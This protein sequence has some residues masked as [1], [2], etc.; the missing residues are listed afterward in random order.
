MG[1]WV[2]LEDATKDNGCMWGVPGSH[3]E[4]TTKFFKRNEDNS[5][6]ITTDSE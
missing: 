2:A 5:G 1:I 3:R 6:T 4:K